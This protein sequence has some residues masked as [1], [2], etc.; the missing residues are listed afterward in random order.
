MK[1]IL[2]ILTI[3]FFSN[4]ILAQNTVIPDQNFEQ[5]LINLGLDTGI[6]NGFVPTVN[7]DT[8][9]SLDVSNNSITN[10]TGIEDFTD[11]VILD[12]SW[13]QITMLNVTQNAQL[14][15]LNCR[16]NQQ[17]SSINVT[18]N[19]LLEKLDCGQ[20]Q[21]TNLDVSQNI[22]LT[23]LRVRFAQLTSLDVTQNTSLRLLNCYSNQITNLNVTQNTD[24]IN[25][26]CS[27]NLLQNI[28]V[29]QNT[30]LITFSCDYNLINFLDVTFN[31]N[32]EGL[33][34]HNNQ[35]TS[36]DIRNNTL[37][38]SLAVSYNQITTLDFSQNP[39][40]WSID[41]LN[42]QISEINISQNPLVEFLA[43]R[44]NNLTCLNVKNGNN[45]NFFYFD[46]F[47]NPNLNCIKVDDPNWS[48]NNWTFIDS[49][50]SFNTSCSNPCLVG[51]E[52]QKLKDISIYPNPTTNKVN[53]ALGNLTDVTITVINV[54]GKIIAVT[55][56]TSKQ[57]QLILPNKKGL[58]FIRLN[59][60][61]E[62]QNFKVIK[63]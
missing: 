22:N 33:W 12:C 50:T 21:I 59:S 38:N 49:W 34:A 6:P 24:L 14:I 17:L 7:I 30:Q 3:V 20:T 54:F 31:V 1:T 23:E 57:H 56:A 16:Q 43:C 53:I 42:N 52:E 51:I 32:L 27:W 37:L 29:S 15:D 46:A 61:G 10:L 8:L 36:I 44:E 55:K 9:T 45:H 19:Q 58:Y 41:C 13:N 60:N 47:D 2:S 48:T 28:D 39:L 25:F 62:T 18:Q 63:E 4:L 26:S 5:E 11:L 35:L 40:M